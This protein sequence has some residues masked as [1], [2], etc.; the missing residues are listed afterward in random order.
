MLVSV[1]VSSSS[2]MEKPELPQTPSGDSKLPLVSLGRSYHPP[3]HL[4][5]K[6][7]KSSSPG[8]S[9]YQDFEE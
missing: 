3:N 9:D 8:L 5:T 6:S 1:L 4:T 7:L 2:H